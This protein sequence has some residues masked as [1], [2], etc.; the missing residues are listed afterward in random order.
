[1]RGERRHPRLFQIEASWPDSTT[2]RRAWLGHAAAVVAATA[3]GGLPR[4]ARAFPDEN[5]DTGHL[6]VRSKSPIDLETPRSALA[7]WRTPNP[8][9]FVRSHLGEPAVTLGPWSVWLGGMVDHERSLS[10]DSLRALEQVTVPAVLQCSGNGRAFFSPTVPGLPWEFGAVGNAEWTGVR[11][12]TLL[13]KAGIKP[14]GQHIHFVGAD[15]PPHP[16]TPAFVRSLPLE[17]ALDANTILAL[18][19]NGEPLPWLHGGPLRL[20]VPGWTG[21]HWMKWL[22]SIT[23]ER[24]EA[25]GFYQQTGYRLPRRPAPP[26]ATIKPEDLVPLT[27]LN[28]KSLLAWPLAGE[29]L[30]RGKHTLQG[31]AWT[32]EGFVKTVEIAIGQRGQWQPATL[33]NDERPFTWRQWRFEWNATTRGHHLIRVRATDSR[34]QTQPDVTPWNRSGYLWNGIDQ[35]S[36]E[37]T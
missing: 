3:V 29:R 4:F 25:Q 32:G 8:F 6:I 34:G 5:T 22:R 13:E 14:G 7:S 27:T 20:V 37:I 23:V 36:C 19:M 35:I 17:K 1:M 10:L 26:G 18:E 12:A 24:D 11:L 31:V 33:L 15:A 2:S 21:N 30:P 9:F 16:K 28:V